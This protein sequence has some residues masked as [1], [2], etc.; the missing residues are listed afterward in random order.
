MI[1]TVIRK[2]TDCACQLTFPNNLHEVLV[3]MHL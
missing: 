1:T 2:G 3:I